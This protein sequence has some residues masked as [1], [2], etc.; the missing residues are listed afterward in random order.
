MHINIKEIKNN[1]LKIAN[2]EI[3]NTNKKGI[4]KC[5]DIIIQ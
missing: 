4:Q 2:L 3:C 5:G 1:I